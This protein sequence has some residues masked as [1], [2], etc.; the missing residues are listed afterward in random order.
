M[1][2]MQWN[3]P[4]VLPLSSAASSP[5]F[6][7]ISISFSIVSAVTCEIRDDN[8]AIAFKSR[9]VEMHKSETEK[10]MSSSG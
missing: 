10:S 4:T 2:E 6:M 5:D 8:S 9:V 3:K 7:P 1:F